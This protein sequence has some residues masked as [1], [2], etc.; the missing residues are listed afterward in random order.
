MIQAAR[1][2]LLLALLSVVMNVAAGSRE[3]DIIAMK[4]KAYGGLHAVKSLKEWCETKYPE[5]AELAGQVGLKL[6]PRIRKVEG[7]L[8]SPNR[9]PEFRRWFEEKFQKR[10]AQSREEDIAH[11][12]SSKYT[13]QTCLNILKHRLRIGVGKKLEAYVDVEE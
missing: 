6:Y 5:T 2:G 3:D 11:Y 10:I 4:M 13:Q 1:L 7:Y 8:F 12:E 9:D